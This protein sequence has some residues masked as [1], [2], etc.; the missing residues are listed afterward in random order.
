MRSAVCWTEQSA[1]KLRYDPSLDPKGRG[2]HYIWE[3]GSGFGMRVYRTGRRT[4]IC[5]TTVSDRQTGVQRSRFFTLGKIPDM[6][7]KAA[8]VAA[9]EK[10]NAMHSG[11]D[12]RAG[13]EDARRAAEVTALA[14]TTLLQGIEYYVLNRNC[15]PRSKADLASTLNANLKDLMQTP[16]LEIETDMLAWG[17]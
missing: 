4:W 1:L 12:P 8:R 10:L 6:S 9:S 15:S 17:C 16:L 3:G 7:L 14:H 5:G 13:E 2:N 11:I